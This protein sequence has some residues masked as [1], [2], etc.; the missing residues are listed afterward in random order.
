MMPDFISDFQKESIALG[1]LERRENQRLELIEENAAL[2]AERDRLR[3]S[4][5]LIQ[6]RAQS[7]VTQRAESDD[8]IIAD[9]IEQVRDIARA[10][11]GEDR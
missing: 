9:H 8:K 11:L 1:E 3:T 10:A 5:R 4:L 2:K 6:S 7:C